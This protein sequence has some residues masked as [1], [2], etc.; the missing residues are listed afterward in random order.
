MCGRR[1]RRTQAACG[2]LRATS[3]TSTCGS[4]PGG[5]PE[6]RRRARAIAFEEEEGWIRVNDERWLA[7]GDIAEITPLSQLR[8][9]GQAGAHGKV[10]SPLAYAK[11]RCPAIRR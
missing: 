1:T 11:T 7:V 9:I 8:P 5:K 4:A 10:Q 6:A 3:G 2:T